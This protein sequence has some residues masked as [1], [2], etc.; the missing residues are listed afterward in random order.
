MPGITE[1]KNTIVKFNSFKS[2]AKCLNSGSVQKNTTA[3]VH[4]DSSLNRY[5]CIRKKKWILM[6]KNRN[7]PMEFTF[8]SQIR[9]YAER[10]N[11]KIIN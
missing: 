11:I 1:Q 3:C 9:Q 2:L 4:Y 6:I 5:G 10:N 8:Y 7:F